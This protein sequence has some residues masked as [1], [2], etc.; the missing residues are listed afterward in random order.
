MILNE[1]LA[2]DSD[3]YG[4]LA[5]SLAYFAPTPYRILLEH[6]ELDDFLQVYMIEASRHWHKR[7][8]NDFK[9]FHRFAY[10]YARRQIKLK[11]VTAR[12]ISIRAIDYTRKL[13][14]RNRVRVA[15]VS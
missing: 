8:A 5:R 4:S 3:L 15:C 2:C 1:K 7:N 13:F 6:N 12:L 9:E 11:G 14:N 10:F